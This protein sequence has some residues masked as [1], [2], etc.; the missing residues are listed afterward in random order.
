MAD[1]VK[2]RCLSNSSSGEP[3]WSPLMIKI[4][5]SQMETGNHKGARTGHSTNRAKPKSHT[6]RKTKKRKL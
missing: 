1:S 3:S 4:W 5:L 6:S 2:V